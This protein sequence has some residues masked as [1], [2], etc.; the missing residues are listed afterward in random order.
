MIWATKSKKFKEVKTRCEYCKN[1]QDNGKT[2]FSKN[3]FTNISTCEDLTTSGHL[4]IAGNRL[5]IDI[6]ASYTEEY[7]NKFKVLDV[8]EYA[9]ELHESIPISYCPLCR[10][11]TIRYT[12]AEVKPLL[13]YFL[14]K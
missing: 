8:Q 12:E 9:V 11:Q 2:I 6:H 3:N 13:L 5:N 10:Q 14:F 4:A 7:F 1:K